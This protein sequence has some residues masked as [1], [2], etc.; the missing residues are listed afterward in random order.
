MN[1]TCPRRRRA[2]ATPRRRVSSPV[3]R[4]TSGRPPGPNEGWPPETPASPNADTLVGSPSFPALCSLLASGVNERGVM[5][6]GVPSPGAGQHFMKDW[7][8]AL[9]EIGVE[10]GV[11]EFDGMPDGAQVAAQGFLVV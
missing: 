8:Q 9:A 7:V 2:A 3:V 11:I 1:A 6:I 10:P 4:R 5:L